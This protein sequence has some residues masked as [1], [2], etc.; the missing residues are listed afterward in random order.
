MRLQN[1][2]RADKVAIGSSRRRYLDV[3]DKLMTS[4]ATRLSLAV[5]I[6]M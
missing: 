1:L 2:S 4:S 5:C 3:A 6:E